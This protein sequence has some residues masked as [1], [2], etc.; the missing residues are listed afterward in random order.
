MSTREADHGV[1]AVCFIGELISLFHL[2]NSLHSIT[3]D[4]VP[5]WKASGPFSTFRVEVL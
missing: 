3:L 4:P 2:F 1:L 5:L